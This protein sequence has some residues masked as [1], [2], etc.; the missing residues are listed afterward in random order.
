LSNRRHKRSP[1]RD[2]ASLL[3][4]WHFAV[5]TALRKGDLRPEDIPVLI[6][7]TRFWH[8]WVSVAF[9]QTYLEVASTASFLPKA[10]EEMQIL[11]NFYLLGRGVFELRHFL[12]NRLDV[13]NIPMRALLYLLDLQALDQKEQR[14]PEASVK[15]STTS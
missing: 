1:L 6:P 4:S 10:R 11:L 14:V 15:H 5:R 12:V 3:H 9:M 2:V 7:W 8:V 13:A